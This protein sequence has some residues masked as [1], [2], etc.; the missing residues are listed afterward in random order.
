MRAEVTVEAKKDLPEDL[1][2]LKQAFKGRIGEP[3]DK[4]EAIDK[5]S[6][7]EGDYEDED[8]IVYAHHNNER[9]ILVYRPELSTLKLHL[10]TGKHCQL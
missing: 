2:T 5:T 1:E 6:V 3:T 7:W 4:R 8:H 10:E 9:V